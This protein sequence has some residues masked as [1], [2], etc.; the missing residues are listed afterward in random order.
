[1]VEQRTPTGPGGAPAPDDDVLL[2][3]KLRLPRECAGTLPRS[4]P[5]DRLRDAT[6]HELTLVCAPAGFGKTTVLADWARTA[7]Q[8]VAWLSLDAGD[9][10]VVRFWGYV[11]AALGQLHG[12]IERQLTALLDG[13]RPFRPDAVTATLVNALTPLPELRAADLAFRAAEAVARARGLG[14]LR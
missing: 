5:A 10:D 4:R 7:S 11:A 1:M 12:G 6:T 13:P 2:A 3:T 8:P 14:L 9:N